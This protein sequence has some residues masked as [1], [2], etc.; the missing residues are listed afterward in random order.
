M[1]D[2]DEEQYVIVSQ[3]KVKKPTFRE[4]EYDAVQKGKMTHFKRNVY[5]NPYD[6]IE[7]LLTD[8]Q[9]GVYH[10]IITY[11]E[12]NV[13]RMRTTRDDTWTED[14]FWEKVHKTLQYPDSHELCTLILESES[15]TQ[16]SLEI[17]EKVG[18]IT[19][20]FMQPLILNLI[21]KNPTFKELEE[22]IYLMNWE[23]LSRFCRAGKFTKASELYDRGNV[24]VH[25]FNGENGWSLLQYAAH[26]NRE[27]IVTWLID[28]LKVEV[29]GTSYD[30]FNA[31]HLACIAG[32]F[33]VAVA[34]YERGASLLSETK[35][36]RDTPITLMITNK[37]TRML[38][39]FI[40][41][42]S[43]YG[44]AQMALCGIRNKE[45][46]K[47]AGMFLDGGIRLPSYSKMLGKI[48]FDMENGN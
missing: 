24:D 48:Y 19:T 33:E 31:M 8:M 34:L 22:Q 37:R 3:L 30:G 42:D 14:V 38:R 27:K 21:E 39:H 43:V 15:D 26:N 47:D 5:V 46:P 6:Y 12:H 28:D 17:K 1:D 13:S 4:I 45:I 20:T 40:G 10:G 18:T 44:K 32:H 7:V 16:F 36:S 41:P 29:D 2:G 11:K 35:S 9:S 25:R 23:K